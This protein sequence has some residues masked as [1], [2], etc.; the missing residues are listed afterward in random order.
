MPTNTGLWI[1]VEG[2]DGAGK[3]TA[4]QT[5]T[6]ALKNHQCDIKVFREP[7]GTAFGEQV[8]HVLKTEGLSILPLAEV[9]L[10]YAARYQLLEKEILPALK[11]GTYVLLD[12]H[13][14]STWAYQAGG[15]GY[16]IHE[17]KKISEVCIQG[18]RPDLTIFL[19]VS[20]E[21][22][23]QRVHLRG[24]LDHIENEGLAFFVDVNQ[25]YETFL[26]DYPHVMRIDANQ[27][28]EKVQLDS[29]S[30]FNQWLAHHLS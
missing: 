13:E 9:L 14:L 2:I 27:S 25:A 24:E 23:Y 6:Q 17:I 7:G 10:F 16:D 30:Q 11:T 1:V 8:R 12:R 19:S 26:E 21:I 4:I 5:I 20:P 3:T 22:A 28:L 15:R 29:L 18:R